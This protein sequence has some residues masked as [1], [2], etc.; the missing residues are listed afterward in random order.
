MSSSSPLT[1]DGIGRLCNIHGEPNGFSPIIQILK[2]LPVN[3]GVKGSDG[4]QK[5][6]YRAILS[7]GNHHCQGM[8]ATQHNHWV[9]SGVLCDN[10]LVKVAD[11]MKN[12][13]Q[14]RPLIILLKFEVVDGPMTK[15]G[16]PTDIGMIGSL[17]SLGNGGGE[18]HGNGNG[19]G[20][21]DVALIVTMDVINSL[22]DLMG[23]KTMNGVEMKIDD[24]LMFESQYPDVAKFHAMYWDR[25]EKELRRYIRL[26]E[27]QDDVVDTNELSEM[28]SGKR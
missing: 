13:V 14:N 10:V 21:N 3:Q 9:E 17:K 5:S 4:G 22:L 23:R 18:R 12:D 1:H 26:Y 28:F 16:T 25:K 20:D 2:V 15:I 7:D 19:N 11:F 8:L 6:R 27:E 24:D